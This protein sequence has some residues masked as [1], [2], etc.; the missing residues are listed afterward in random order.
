MRTPVR[1]VVSLG[2][3]GLLALV[4]L[5]GETGIAQGSTKFTPGAPGLGDPYF[6]TL[7]NGGYDVGHYGLDLSYDPSRH[8]LAG[9]AAITAKATQNLSRFDL[10]LNGLSV[11]SVVVNSVAAPWAR[12]GEEL[13]VTPRAGLPKGQAFTVA[14]D[15]AGSPRTVTGS[16]I[17]FGADYG[18]KYTPDG[19]FVGDEPN[20]AHTWFPGNDHPSD[21]ATFTMKVSV[22]VGTAVAGNGDLVSHASS[23]G[24]TTWVWDETSPMAT[25]LATIDIGRWTFVD[26]RTPGGIRSVSAYDPA[27][28]GDVRRVIDKAEFGL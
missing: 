14:V 24:R 19:A 6:P 9:T 28:Q 2:A 8:W 25:Y 15:Y 4:L 26:G 10:D 3:T 5:T 20:A 7:G 11:R 27:L 22:P 13:Q 1:T 12:V 17:V 23:G 18:W 21:K 16:P